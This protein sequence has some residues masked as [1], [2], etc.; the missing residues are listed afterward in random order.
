MRLSLCPFPD[1]SIVLYAIKPVEMAM[2]AAKWGCQ[3]MPANF[4]DKPVLI[5]VFVS[6]PADWVLDN[7]GVVYSFIRAELI[8]PV[9]LN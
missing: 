6:A 7:I 5:E 3:V 8:A 2:A 4:P 9:A 1:A